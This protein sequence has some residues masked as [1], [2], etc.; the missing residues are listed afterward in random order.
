VKI[1]DFG[2]ALLPSARRLTW[3]GLSAVLGTPDYMAPE[4]I[5]GRRGDART[6]VYAVGMLLYEMLTG[7]LPFEASNA[8]AVLRAKMDVEPTRPTR[9]VPGLDRALEATIL[10]ALARDPGERHAS[11]AD[12]LRDLT[13]PTPAPR[14]DAGE[15][16]RRRSCCRAM[17][18]IG[19]SVAVALVLLGMGSLL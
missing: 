12:L 8:A 2:I 17:R 4:Q 9:Y 19:L 10:R 7:R 18:A 13:A 6:D 16:R 1:L 11:A 14:Y 15:G 5:R 3:A